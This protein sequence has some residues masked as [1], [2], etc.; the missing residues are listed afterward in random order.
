M[1]TEQLKL[2]LD[3]LKG[4]SG[5]ATNAVIWYFVLSNIVP[6]VKYSIVSVAIYKVVRLFTDGFVVKVLK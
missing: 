6:I 1:D 2:I 4:V 5:D 3:L